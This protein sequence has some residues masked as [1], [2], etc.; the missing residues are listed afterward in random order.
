MFSS[1]QNKMSILC[2]LCGK[3]YPTEKH[4]QIHI[5]NTDCNSEDQQVKRKCSTYFQHMKWQF[6]KTVTTIPINVVPNWFEINEYSRSV[7]VPLFCAVA[8][9]HS[10]CMI[11]VCHWAS[12]LKQCAGLSNMAAQQEIAIRY[13]TLSVNIL[14]KYILKNVWMSD[15][16][17]EP[18]MSWFPT[19]NLP[20]P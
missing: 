1:H 14:N 13:S 18:G 17:L 9:V 5:A 15:K 8:I 12:E 10:Q 2:T 6:A 7:M 20:P 3:E 19:K 11:T 16:G 4:L